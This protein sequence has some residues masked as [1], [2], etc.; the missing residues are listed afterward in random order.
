MIRETGKHNTGG[1]AVAATT[2]TEIHG[3]AAPTD[4]K[5]ADKTKTKTQRV[6][7]EIKLR[8]QGLPPPTDG[9]TLT[10]RLMAQANRQANGLG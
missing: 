6:L 5:A 9:Q 4:L 1:G 8:S 2:D 7:L 10:A 3:G